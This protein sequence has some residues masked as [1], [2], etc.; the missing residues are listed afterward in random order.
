MSP[1]CILKIVNGY[2][3]KQLERRWDFV[4]MLFDENLSIKKEMVKVVVESMPNCE[5]YFV[6]RNAFQR[7][8]FVNSSIFDEVFNNGGI[9]VFIFRG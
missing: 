3:V 4:Q 7:D 1:K 5:I 6:A 9:S 2:D 8:R